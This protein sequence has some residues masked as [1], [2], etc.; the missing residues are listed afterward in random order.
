ML[1][2]V[3]DAC[4][5]FKSLCCSDEMVNPGLYTSHTY[6]VMQDEYNKH[7]VMYPAQTDVS[8]LFVNGV[9]HI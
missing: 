8:D 9:Y 7:I 5:H 6:F 4:F 2:I 3:M 1:F